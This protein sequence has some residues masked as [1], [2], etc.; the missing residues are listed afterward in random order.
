VARLERK[1]GRVEAARTAALKGLSVRADDIPLLVEHAAIEAQIALTATEPRVRH[2]AAGRTR[3][4]VDQLLVVAPGHPG[5][6]AIKKSVE[7]I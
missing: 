4:A 7:R 1:Q 3:D 5:A 2:Q 6:D